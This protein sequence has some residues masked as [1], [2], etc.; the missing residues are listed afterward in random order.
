[1]LLIRIE[2]FIH[3]KFKIIE[4]DVNDFKLLHH[5]LEWQ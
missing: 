5:R 2:H 4:N 1:M 3:I